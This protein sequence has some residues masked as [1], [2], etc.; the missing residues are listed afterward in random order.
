MSTLQ[1]IRPVRLTIV[2][3]TESSASRDLFD[4]RTLVEQA[5]SDPDA[6][7]VLYRHYVDR[8]HTFA[9]RR[10]GSRGAAEDITSATFEAAY[11]NLD[12]FRWRSG[13]FAPWLFRI[14]A[15]QAIAHHRREQR[16]ATA[17]GQ[18]AMARMHVAST[19]DD[20]LDRIDEV[21]SDPALTEALSRLSDRYQ[22]VIS[23]RYLAGLDPD[24]AARAM[25]LAKP[26][27]AV[28]LSRALAALRREVARMENNPYTDRGGAS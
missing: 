15:N 18:Q 14:A 7:A 6:F 10:S 4:E 8:I 16:P 19:V 20:E 2:S 28:V 26:A 27:L 5:R 21:G 17:R 12:Q 22:R 25:G 23:L 3:S 9:V 11:R 13:G 1:A 24:E